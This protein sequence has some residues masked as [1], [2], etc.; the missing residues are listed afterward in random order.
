MC[1]VDSRPFLYQ[2]FLLRENNTVRCPNNLT[3]AISRAL[4]KLYLNFPD[5][6]RYRWLTTEQVANIMR[7]GG[8]SGITV[9]HIRSMFQD[10]ARDSPYIQTN[11]FRNLR[12]FRH[13]TNDGV[14][15]KDEENGPIA[16]IQKGYFFR[17]PQKYGEIL[18]EIKNFEPAILPVG[19]QTRLSRT[20]AESKSSE[21]QPNQSTNESNEA[22]K[23][24]T[25]INT[26]A[27]TAKS[28]HSCHPCQ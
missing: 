12:Y 4:N 9:K 27:A 21:P 5:D 16:C 26:A 18:A 13:K 24:I 10:C 7:S 11:V 1:C 28:E 19:A 6:I 14:S 3:M 20:K 23:G 2:R 15:P 22:N 25:T 17:H 8:L